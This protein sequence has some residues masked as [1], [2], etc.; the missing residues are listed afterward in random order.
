MVKNSHSV[1][2]RAAVRAHF[3]AIYSPYLHFVRKV[4]SILEFCRFTIILLSFVKHQCGSLWSTSCVGILSKSRRF[5]IRYLVVGVVVLCGCDKV[6]IVDS[7]AGAVDSGTNDGAVADGSLVDAS[8]ADAQPILP[9]ANIPPT[10]P[11]NPVTQMGCT[12]GEKCGR[13]V[14][15]NNPLVVETTCLPAG[16]NSVG[17]NCAYGA[18]GAT[19]GYDDCSA[20]LD[21]AL[22]TCDEICS[23]SPDS[24]PEDFRCAADF[25]DHFTDETGVC[26]PTCDPTNDTVVDGNATNNT[27]TSGTSCILIHTTGVTVCAAIPTQSATQTQNEIPVGSGGVPFANGCASGFSTLLYENVGIPTGDP[28]CTRFCTPTETYQGI[29]GT[30]TGSAVGANGKCSD[31]A[32]DELGGRNGNDSPHQCRFIQSFYA[33]TDLIP[34]S[35]GMC[36]PV[37]ASGGGQTLLLGNGATAGPTWGDC[38][39]FEWELLRDSW[40]AAAPNGQD[41]VNTAFDNFCL[42][43]PSDPSNSTILDRCIGY[44]YGCLS[45]QMTDELLPPAAASNFSLRSI[46]ERYMGNLG[47]QDES[48]MSYSLQYSK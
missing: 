14:L 16:S 10:G 1:N 28:H 41:A 24:C 13:L 22:G 20:G 23:S 2:D 5:G 7:D 36:V 47:Q 15:S 29:G 4:A 38:T 33:N 35:T 26:V 12:A 37:M 32:L 42:S 44:F 21:C 18:P 40:N 46:R 19:S 25:Q 17:Q 6:K 27:C 8:L 48:G 9:D 43:T 45:V 11:C 3:L 34:A 30:Q 31:S 39:L